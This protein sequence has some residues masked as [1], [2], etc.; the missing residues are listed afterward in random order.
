MS[1]R[2]LDTQAATEHLSRDRF[3]EHELH[4]TFLGLAR[5]IH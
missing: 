4:L 3:F 5:Q 1:V 2:G